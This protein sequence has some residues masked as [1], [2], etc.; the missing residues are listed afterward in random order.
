MLAALCACARRPAAGSASVFYESLVTFSFPRHSLCCPRCPLHPFSSIPSRPAAATVL[1]FDLYNDLNRVGI[2]ISS[3]QQA[4]FHVA[5]G[6]TV[7]YTAY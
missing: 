1:V 2:R 3:Q 6:N 5:I 7:R 4:D